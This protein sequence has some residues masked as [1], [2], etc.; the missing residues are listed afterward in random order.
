MNLYEKINVKESEQIEGL[1]FVPTLGSKELDDRDGFPPEWPTGVN[2]HLHFSEC[3]KDHF[4]DLYSRVKDTCGA[5][6]EIGVWGEPHHQDNA[7]RSTELIQ[8]MK[9]KE[10][11]YLGVDINDRSFVQDDENN[12]HFL[13][14]DSMDTEKIHAK[15]K[16]LGIEGF[17]FI[18]IDGWH[19]VNAVLHEWKHYV[20]PFLNKGGILVFHDTNSHPG[21]YVLFDSIDEEVF[22]SEKYCLGNHYG[23]G[24]IWYRKDS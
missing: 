22:E 1:A 6:L 19:S 11:I 15:I 14:S 16:E 7:G 2:T 17:D 10:T 24:A 5:I 20:I 21:P 4:V 18:F 3:T 9:N 8:E 23:L 13:Q 12:F